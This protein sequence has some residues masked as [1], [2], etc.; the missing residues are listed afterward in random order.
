MTAKWF[1]DASY[2]AVAVVF[3]LALKAMSSP[4]TARRGIVWGGIA[5][6]VFFVAFRPAAAA[7]F[8]GTL[9]SV[10]GDIFRGVGEFFGSLVG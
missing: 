6:V 8:I 4:V 3:I 5:F 10:V 7:D 9:G 1:I 2:F